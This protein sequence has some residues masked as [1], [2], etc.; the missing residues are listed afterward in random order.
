MKDEIAIIIPVFKLSWF[1]K[2]PIK[3]DD[4]A[5][6]PICINPI[7]PDAIP[8]NSGTE[9]IALAVPRG[10]K[11]PLPNVKMEIASILVKIGN[12]LMYI[13]NPNKRPPMKNIF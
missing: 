2:I 6:L 7:I 3:Y 11:K 5:A 9:P 4:A 13:C 10:N 1:D 8:D 12:G